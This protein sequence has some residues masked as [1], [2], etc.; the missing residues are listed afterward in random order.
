MLLRR[1]KDSATVTFLVAP[2]S[3]SPSPRVTEINWFQLPPPLLISITHPKLSVLW[4]IIQNVAEYPQLQS[5]FLYR[6]WQL[7]LTF[8]IYSWLFIVNF[9]T[10]ADTYSQLLPF[11]VDFS[12]YSQLFLQVLIVT[13]D[14]FHLQSAFLTITDMFICHIVYN[15]SQYMDNLGATEI[16]RGGLKTKSVFNC[17]GCEWKQIF[18]FRS[19]R[20]MGGGGGTENM[21]FWK[22]FT[23]VP[24]SFWPPLTPTT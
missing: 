5:S 24:L 1:V 21:P 17:P 3:F 14:F 19:P 12:I 16:N 18:C 13:V 20:G 4:Y 9:F 6:C 8:S 22:C 2:F 23:S 10:G 15:I 11:T 7:Q